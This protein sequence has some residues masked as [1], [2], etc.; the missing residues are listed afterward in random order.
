[1]I[2][3]YKKLLDCETKIE[4]LK[5]RKVRFSLTNCLQIEK[6]L[7]DDLKGT[8]Q[9][10]KSKLKASKYTKAKK[11]L[12]RFS[13]LIQTTDNTP[14][15]ES[16]TTLYRTRWDTVLNGD[17][18]KA[19]FD[20]CL[21]IFK[22]LCETLLS[23]SKEQLD[24]VFEFH[25]QSDNFFPI[26]Y[27]RKDLSKIHISENIE[28]FD[29]ALLENYCK[30]RKVLSDDDFNSNVKEFHD[31]RTKINVKA[32]KTDRSK[33]GD[34]K[35]NREYRWET[36]PTSPQFA[37][38]RDCVGVEYILLIQICNFKNIE[39]KLKNRLIELGVLEEKEGIYCCPVTG[40]ELDY[41]DFKKVASESK[42]H[43]KSSFQVGH[44]K[45]LKIG[46]S[47]TPDNI[48]WQTEDGNRIQGNLSLLEVDEMLREIYKLRPELKK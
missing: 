30:L 25:K 26:D 46:G 8:L 12:I 27:L 42:V 4:R 34:Y 1:M 33:T 10:L 36:L 2:Y 32:Y 31:F 11:T 37:T 21:S 44:L 29:D 5:G 7:D 16:D 39:C 24:K 22:Q 23:Y 20:E 35:T 45:P 9:D 6:Y 18:R 48:G 41:N 43:G 17:P 40:R 38:L 14:G 19:S 15:I 47:H 28:F 13:F 3:E